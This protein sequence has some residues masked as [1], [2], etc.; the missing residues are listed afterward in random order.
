MTHT[1]TIIPFP[2]HRARPSLLRSAH[3]LAALALTDTT[4]A[5]WDSLPVQDP[6]RV[7]CADLTD[8]LP[9]LSP[10]TPAPDAGVLAAMVADFSVL[11]LYAVQTGQWMRP[12]LLGD[13]IALQ[14]RAESLRISAGGAVA[15]RA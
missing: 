13:L 7:S 10:D 12:D 6:N 2:I 14:S 11:G 15:Q 3:S 8:S 9:T 1:P 4:L 5:L